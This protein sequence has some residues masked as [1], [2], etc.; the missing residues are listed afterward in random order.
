MPEML[1]DCCITHH[2]GQAMHLC[3]GRG[4]AMHSHAKHAMPSLALH[5]D[6]KEWNTRLFCVLNTYS[7]GA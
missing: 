2:W 7:N 3:W 5:H 1:L 4:A 6:L